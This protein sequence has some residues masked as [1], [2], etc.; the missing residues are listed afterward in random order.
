MTQHL[1]NIRQLIEES[2]DL[3]REGRHAEAIERL[4]DAIASVSSGALFD[5]RGYV[6]SDAGDL[7][8]AL[9]D[10][11]MAVYLEPFNSGYLLN[12]GNVLLKQSKFLAAIEDFDR[13][14]EMAP[15]FA[16]AHNS[17]AYCYEEVRRC[18][19]A[20]AGYLRSIEIAPTDAS[21]RFRLGSLRLEQGNLTQ[22]IDSLTQAH[23]L[24][25]DDAKP[26]NLRGDAY[27][28]LGQ[29]QSAL[30]DYEQATRLTPDCWQAV[31]RLAWLLGTC[32]DSS[33]RNG[34]RA[35]ELATRA[36]DLTAWKNA[37]GL[38]ALAAAHAERGDFDE[39]ARWQSAAIAVLPKDE[40]SDA[41]ERLEQFRRREPCRQ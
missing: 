23:E 17:R 38:E 30:R 5:A 8:A 41:T 7:E 39:A 13:A 11:S 20:V 40:V 4:S 31:W 34:E 21:P 3:R 9:R 27:C 35:V 28:E 14:I 16:K 37:C 2:W 18:D 10:Q 12:R 32:R 29:F 15:T 33:I 26:I 24:K 1:H 19:D 25:P 6:Y 22:A 36:C